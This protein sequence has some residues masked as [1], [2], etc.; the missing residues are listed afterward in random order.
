[1][2]SQL[3]KSTNR[4][5]KKLSNLPTKKK[6]TQKLDTNRTVL[7]L[8]EVQLSPEGIAVLA[9]RGNYA[10]TPYQPS[11]EDTIS[12]IEA[13]I[14][15]LTNDETEEIRQETAR[16]LQDAKPTNTNLTGKE[17]QALRSLNNNKNLIVL[18][19]DK[20]TPR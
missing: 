12:N 4:H 2:R 10:M 7:N 1:M 17:R 20:T 3:L 8:S 19:A 9:K 16:I 5:K 15:G 14:R 13:G 11:S 18:A 6:F